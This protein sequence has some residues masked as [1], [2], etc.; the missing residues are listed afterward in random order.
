MYKDGWKLIQNTSERYNST[1]FQPLGKLTEFKYPELE[2]EYELYN[3]QADFKES[4]DL[5]NNRTDIF[6]ET[7]RLL[8]TFKRDNLLMQEQ[9]QLQLRK[10]LEDF[11]SLGYIK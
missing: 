8:Q 3:I 6:K 10:K 2:K 7:K 5:L 11:R 4:Q 1:F 9:K